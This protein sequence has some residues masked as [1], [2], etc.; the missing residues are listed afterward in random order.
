MIHE[1]VSLTV[2]GADGAAQL[3][4]YAPDA[5]PELGEGRRRAA[6]VICPGGGYEFLSDREGE[7]VALRFAGLG[8]AAFVLKYH[9][10]PQARWPV[11][12]RQLLAAID[13][14]R[15]NCG[16]YHADPHAV[17]A[18]GFS[19]GGHLAGCAG[20]M[21]NKAE[22]YRPLHRRPS[23]FRPDG[24][25]M[26]YPVVSG[27]QF[28]HRGSIENLLGERLEEL[29]GLVSLEKRATRNAP[30][31]FIW[32]T[33]DDTCVPVENSMLL[34]NALQ[35]KGVDTELHI[36]PHG[37]HGQS[38]ADGTVYA[39]QDA[40][41]ASPSCAVWVSHCD[42]WLR[43]RFGEFAVPSHPDEKK[44]PEPPIS[45]PETPAGNP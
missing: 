19:A 10:A 9:V 18:M 25:V 22:L 29:N 2:P 8:Y 12:Q 30:P 14:V 21:W 36:Y 20:L 42:Q 16:R 34:A 37:V 39:P 33:A 24:V 45:L 32:H 3:I 27:V 15:G 43:R 44:P 28:A 35:A 6:L 41:R 1:T 38:L 40:W 13:Y 4:T 23:A 11:P 17:I 31:F 5:S 7:P 26:C